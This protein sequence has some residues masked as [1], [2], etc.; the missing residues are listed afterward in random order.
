MEV[1]R[2]TAG[3]RKMAACVL[4]RTDTNK[5][6]T[7]QMDL[8]QRQLVATAP[9]LSL[10][11]TGYSWWLFCHYCVAKHLVGYLMLNVYWMFWLLVG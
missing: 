3:E 7:H 8:Q 10:L 9:S 5:M 1:D 11:A 2:R 6:E 4:V